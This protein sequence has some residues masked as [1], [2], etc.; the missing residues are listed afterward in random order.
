MELIDFYDLRLAEPYWLLLLILP[1]LLL[2]LKKSKRGKIPTIKFSDVE[3]LHIS[4][5]S[6]RS[7][8]KWFP[9]LL[10]YSGMVFII[11][12]IAGPQQEKST[13]NIQASGVDIVLAV[14]LSASMLALDMSPSP[15]EPSTRLDV[16]KDVIREFIKKR[17]FDRIGLV[18]FARNNYLVSGLTLDKQF[19]QKKLS[20][21]EVGQ[22]EWRDTSIGSALAEGINRLNTVDSKSK[23]LILLTDGKDFPPPKH[24]PLIY[25]EGAKKDNIKIH[26]IA[27]GTDSSTRTYVYDPKADGG[28]GGIAKYR[29][30]QPVV[31]IADFEVDKKIL[32]EI[33]FTTNAKFF[34]AKNKDTLRAIYEEID[35]MEK[36]DF[37]Q[38]ISTLYK[39]LYQV[40]LG[41]GIFFLIS[42]FVL[43]RTFY[44][45]LP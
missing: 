41:L 44:L 18:A 14:D 22:T 31:E 11:I 16:V 28:R 24:S 45:R 20:D 10:F 42:N 13:R 35:A 39:E 36:S 25:A 38:D 34:E 40:P 1:A 9:N 6:F 26:T 33:A 17:K 5:R 27:I 30:G 2:W 43:K 8:T 19:L 3:K 23:I 37:Q 7:L 4:Q 32:Q 12:S 15:E 29:N 21:L